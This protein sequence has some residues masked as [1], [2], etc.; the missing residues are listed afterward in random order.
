MLVEDDT[1]STNTNGSAVLVRVNGDGNGNRAK[2]QEKRGWDWRTGMRKGAIG[3]D[4]LS[5]LRLGLAKEI[6]RAWIED[7]EA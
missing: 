7:E 4:L 3:K 2:G 6:A 1:E 5:I